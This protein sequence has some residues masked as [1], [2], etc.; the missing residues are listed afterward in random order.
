MLFYCTQHAGATSTTQAAADKDTEVKL[1]EIEEVFKNKKDEV[2]KTLLKR[3]TLVN[4]ELHRN[5]KKLDA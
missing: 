1:K 5:L 4:P 2:V 3:A